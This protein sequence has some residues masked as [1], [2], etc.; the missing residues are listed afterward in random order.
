MKFS[1]LAEE[2]TWIVGGAA[3]ATSVIVYVACAWGP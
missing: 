2:V 3:A 1:S